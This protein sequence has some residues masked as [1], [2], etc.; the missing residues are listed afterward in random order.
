M[1]S[2]APHPVRSVRQPAREGKPWLKDA[3]EELQREGL[4]FLADQIGGQLADNL[5]NVLRQQGLTVT[6]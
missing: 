6:S 4:G 5:T 3:V 1:W 2:G